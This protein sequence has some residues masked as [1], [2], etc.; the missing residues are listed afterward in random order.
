MFGLS[1]DVGLLLRTFS[2]ESS[3]LDFEVELFGIGMTEFCSRILF[4]IL[5]LA[6]LIV[7]ALD[8]LMLVPL[9]DGCGADFNDDLD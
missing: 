6:L 3:V 9:P 1:K 7:F 2:S 4:G 8:V 5:T